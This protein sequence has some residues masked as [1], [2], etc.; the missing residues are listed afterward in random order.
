MPSY[1]HINTVIPKVDAEDLARGR[2]AFSADMALEDPLVLRVLRSTESHARI[3]TLDTT[4]GLKI[5]GVMGILTAKDI[6]GERFYGLIQKDQPLLADDRVRFRGEA[7]AVLV[8]TDEGAAENALDAIR[9]DYEPLVTV[10]DPEDALKQGAP[11]VHEKGNLLYRRYLRKGDVEEGFSRS[12]VRVKRHYITPCLEHCYLEPDAG[13]GYVDKDGVL[14]IYASTQNP[15]YDQQ[16]VCRLLGLQ[17]E[18]VRI[19]QKNTGGGFGSKLDL[20]TQGFI[21]LALYHFRRPVRLIYTRE[22]AFQ[23]TSKRHPF[24]I[25]MESGA[26]EQGKLLAVKARCICDTGA[27]ASYGMAVAIRAAVHAT[28]PYEVENVEVE[29]LCVYTNNPVAGAMRGFGA[30]QMAVAYESQ[31]DLMAQEMGIDPM[32]LRKANALRVGSRTATGQKLDASVGMLRALEAVEPYYKEAVDH[33]KKEN[34]D[35]AK[36]RGIGLGAMWYGIG[37]TGVKNPANARIEMDPAGK[38]VLYTGVADIGQGSSTVL[39]QIA[40]E[41]LDVEPNAIMR[42]IGDTALTQSAGATSASRQTYISGNAV[43]DAAEKLRLK[44]LAEATNTLGIPGEYLSLEDGFVVSK[45][46][47][48]HRVSVK[49]LAKRAYGEERTLSCSGYFDPKTTPLDPETAQGIPYGTYAF[50]CQIAFVEVDTET[51]NVYVS[52]VI[53]AHDVGKAIHPQNV[54]GQIQGGVAMGLGFALMEE[55]KPGITTSMADYHIPTGMDMPEIVPII[56]EEEEPTGP[57]GAKGVGEPA[58]IPTAPAILNGIADAT[59]SRIY[60]L[61][62][63]PERVRGAI[64][65]TKTHERGK[66][67]KA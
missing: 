65:H 35:N 52:R 12:R 10:F 51:G 44:L 34:P 11:L 38:V 47:P 19:I 30:P 24:R 4:E 42:V 17:P 26:S 64:S 13:A 48:K 18:Q 50:A 59:G 25:E 21:G 46:D 49:D 67:H 61:P 45:K 40:A 7:M 55:F 23:A 63:S 53:A 66:W 29:C 3:R 31:M 54:E 43:M 58:L 15:H 16:D 57:F 22:E 9:V 62:A 28:G 60:R 56:V 8:A 1:K 36:K 33:W 32:E 2:S 6:P 20:T 41:I 37:N 27:Y 14:V 39:S 5:P